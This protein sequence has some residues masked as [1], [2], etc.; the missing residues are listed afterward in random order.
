MKKRKRALIIVLSMALSLCLFG[1]AANA[2]LGLFDLTFRPW[3]YTAGLVVL[4]M[5]FIA[6][7][8]LVI[9]MLKSL[10]GRKD[11][12]GQQKTVFQKAG[13]WAGI[14]FVRMSDS[15]AGAAVAA[16]PCVFLLPGAQGGKRRKA[17]AGGGKQLF[18]RSGDLLR[19]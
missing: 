9:S 14:V 4:P 13:C 7:L 16:E 18:A 1:W 19:L 8:C 10:A 17:H 2:V 5:L 15:A 6:A 3:V 11:S 12:K